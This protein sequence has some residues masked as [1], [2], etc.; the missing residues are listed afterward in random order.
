MANSSEKTEGCLSTLNRCFNKIIDME[1]VTN[2]SMI[3]SSLIVLLSCFYSI[4]IVSVMFAGNLQLAASN[5]ATSWAV[6]TGFS[7]I[8]GLNAAVETLCRQSPTTTYT[9]LQTSCS[10][11]FFFSTAI[12]LLWWYSDT[13]LIQLFHQDHEIAKEAGL[14][15]KFLIP[16]LFGYGL[17]QNAMRFLRAHSI[18]DPIL[19]FSMASLVIHIAIIAYA[20]V[21]W[22]GLGFKGASLATSISIWIQLIIF[23]LFMFFSKHIKWDYAF[24]FE[25]FHFQHILTNLK[26]ALPSAAMVCLEYCAFEILVLL[27]GLMP[28]PETSISIIA[29]S[30]NTQA[31]AHM[32]FSGLSVGV[33]TRVAKELRA[34]NP[35]GAKHVVAVAFKQTILL[36]YVLCLAL[37][38]HHIAW[39][40]LFSDSAEI[41]NKFTSMVPLLLISFV[42]EFTQG[43]LS[44][45]VRGCGWERYAMCID[46]AAF[47]FIGIPIAV[48]VVFK[49][50]LHAQVLWIGLICGLA[51]QTF[52]L[53][54]LVLLTR[55]WKKLEGSTNSNRESE[56]SA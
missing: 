1:E 44:G 52:G 30:V 54:L 34:G 32:L 26:L 14:F 21:H 27:A 49:L 11:S 6:I 36:V 29:M 28:N 37:L 55:S 41:V 42:L 24:S 8:F 45:V 22:T 43:N 35:E 5:L 3:S 48:L 51:C 33:S 40:G 17:L 9:L 50:S 31:I 16:G 47:Y 19:L 46:L 4:N 15:L 20:L 2:Q 23:C 13:I 38:N 25:P 10:I 56:L 53:S 12:A 18:L 39:A 7:F